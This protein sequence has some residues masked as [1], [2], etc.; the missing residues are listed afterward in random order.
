[1]SNIVNHCVAGGAAGV[2]INSLGHQSDKTD[3]QVNGGINYFT[4]FLSRA[5]PTLHSSLDYQHL[6]QFQQIK[7]GF[8][9]V[10]QGS[11]VLCS[12]HLD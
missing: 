9:F 4:L 5:G 7:K 10:V 6:P 3:A 2:N 12:V 8:L 1:M 11:P